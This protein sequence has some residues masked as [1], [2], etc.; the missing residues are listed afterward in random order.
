[1][2]RHHG[3]GAAVLSGRDVGVSLYFGRWLR[4]RVAQGRLG[5]GL[6]ADEA[7]SGDSQSK[8]AQGT[9]VTAKPPVQAAS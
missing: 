5:L 9:G 8:D 2:G 3:H 7:K 1:M 4:V 6:M